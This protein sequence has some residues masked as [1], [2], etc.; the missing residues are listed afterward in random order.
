VWLETTFVV[1][2]RRT[3]QPR[4]CFEEA[5]GGVWYRVDVEDLPWMTRLL[6][7]LG[8][9]FIVRE[10]PELCEV[11]HEYARTL[12]SYAERMAATT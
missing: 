9:P 10:P 6:A 8:V 12:V 3:G 11:I 4:A 5:D 1:A 2:H 7:G